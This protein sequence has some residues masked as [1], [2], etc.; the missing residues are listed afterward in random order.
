MEIFPRNVKK[1]FHTN[2]NKKY[3]KLD[4]I[5]ILVKFKRFFNFYAC[6]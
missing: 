5:M 6:V 2:R 4:R 3:S 1:F